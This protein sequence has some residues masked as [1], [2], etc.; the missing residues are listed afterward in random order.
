M[1]GPRI[2]S[3]GPRSVHEDHWRILPLTTPTRTSSNRNFLPIV[4][5]PSLQL[6]LD[7][8]DLKET[9]QTNPYHMGPGTVRVSPLK[10]TPTHTLH[11]P[12]LDPDRERETSRSR[13]NRTPMMSRLQG[14]T[15]F[16]GTLKTFQY[17][18]GVKTRNGVE[19]ST[20]FSLLDIK[21]YSTL[22]STGNSEADLRGREG[23]DDWGV[24]R[25]CPRREPTREEKDRSVLRR[26]RKTSQ[27][28]GDEVY[29]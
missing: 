4:T 15:Q 16:Q 18:T 1:F 24:K 11:R 29:L 21:P 7:D 19:S 23:R 12:R 2:G 8:S 25:V 20:C 3:P 28:K 9:V 22:F 17:Y 10:T 13:P 5:H 26:G 14:K 6:R 27:C